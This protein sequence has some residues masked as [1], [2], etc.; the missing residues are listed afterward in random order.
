MVY[1][2]PFCKFA[3]PC[4][5]DPRRSRLLLDN[6]EDWEDIIE[7]LEANEYDKALAVTK[8]K[9]TKNQNKLE[10]PNGDN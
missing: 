5:L 1:S 10:S 4:T 3:V 7:L 8:K 6:I 2:Y 9:R